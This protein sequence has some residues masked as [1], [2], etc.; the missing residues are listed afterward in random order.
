MTGKNFCAIDIEA[1]R[2]EPT[3]KRKFFSQASMS[4]FKPRLN[5]KGKKPRSKRNW[6][7]TTANKQS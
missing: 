2:Y 7:K 4:A 5:S 3:A 1:G 6:L